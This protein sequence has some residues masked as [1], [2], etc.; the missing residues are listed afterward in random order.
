ML[1]PLLSDEP[2]AGGLESGWIARLALDFIFARGAT[3]LRFRHEGPLRIQKPLYPDG[4]HCCH[5]VVVHPPGGIAGGDQLSIDI[6]VPNPAHALVTTPSATKWYGTFGGCCATQH[7][8]IDLDGRLEWLPSE[9]IVFDRAQ[10]VSKISISASQTGTML[11]W[12]LLVFGRHG[13]GERFDV[14]CFDQTLKVQFDDRLVWIDRLRLCGGDD[15]FE[16]PIGLGGQHALST[17][18]AIAPADQT[19]TDQHLADLRQ[20]VSG[21]AWTLLH[22]R[23]LVGRQVGDPNVMRVRLQSAWAW[24]K[25]ECWVLPANELRLWAT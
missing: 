8:Q 14:G 22:P 4:P 17:F 23:L 12:D 1:A 6:A 21:I 9:T 15:L 18:W 3:A 7:V 11:G 20:A 25:R 24:I 13:S 5:A 19:W 10:V 2:V 16:S